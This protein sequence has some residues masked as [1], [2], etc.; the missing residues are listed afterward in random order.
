MHERFKT[1]IANAVALAFEYVIGTDAVRLHSPQPKVSRRDSWIGCVDV[2]DGALRVSL[3]FSAELARQVAA[4]MFALPGAQVTDADIEDAVGELCSI[5]SGK[6]KILAVPG[7]DMALP[8]VLLDSGEDLPGTD[9]QVLC[10]LPFSVGTN[11]LLLTLERD[12]Y[13]DVAA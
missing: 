5:V 12:R 13:A 7:V 4:T 6:V 11:W 2:G 1:T 9:A 3:A 10:E 8:K